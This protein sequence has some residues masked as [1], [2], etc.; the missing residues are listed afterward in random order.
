MWCGEEGEEAWK[1]SGTIWGLAFGWG[2]AK[3][4]QPVFGR[5]C[6]LLGAR[7]EDVGGREGCV[8]V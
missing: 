1:G 3:R 7:G 2:A 5:G 8:C 4:K 6:V